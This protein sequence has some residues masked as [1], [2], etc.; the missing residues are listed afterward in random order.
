MIYWFIINLFRG[1]KLLDDVIFY[2]NN[3]IVYS[4]C[5]FL[6]MGYKDKGNI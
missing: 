5:F 6:V 4:Y 3:F 1:V 2:N